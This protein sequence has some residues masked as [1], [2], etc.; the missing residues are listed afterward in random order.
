MCPQPCQAGPTSALPLTSS[1]VS[2]ASQEAWPRSF[3]AL[4]LYT[5]AS[6]APQLRSHRQLGSGAGVGRSCPSRNQLRLG[7]GAPLTTTR[8]RTSLPAH[9]AA[10]FSGR[11]KTGAP[12]PAPGGRT[13]LPAPTLALFGGTPGLGGALVPASSP[14]VPR[15]FCM[16]SVSCTRGAGDARTRWP[17]GRPGGYGALRDGS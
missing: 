3:W 7:S 15:P 14:R 1:T 16:A 5:P 13:P 12:A 11:R 2:T 6:C 4:Q 10:F 9:T 17:G 8:S